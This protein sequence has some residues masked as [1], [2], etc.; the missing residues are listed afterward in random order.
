M[1][2]LHRVSRLRL[3]AIESTGSEGLVTLLSSSCHPIAA[4]IVQIL[5]KKFCECRVLF[6]THTLLNFQGPHPATGHALHDRARFLRKSLDRVMGCFRHWSTG[7]IQ[8][9]PK[10]LQRLSL[11]GGCRHACFWPASE[12]TFMPKTQEDCICCLN[13]IASLNYI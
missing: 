10:S 11:L 9:Y 3:L 7:D 5:A 2:A 8:A 4:T 1:P 13:S 6:T 12:L